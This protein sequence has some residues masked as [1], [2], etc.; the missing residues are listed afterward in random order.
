MFPPM[1]MSADDELVLRPAMCPH[2]ALIFASRPRSYRDLP[3]RIAEIGGQ[4][5]AERSGVLGA[6]VVCAGCR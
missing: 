3:V 4:Y 6:S 1:A 5:R 2:H